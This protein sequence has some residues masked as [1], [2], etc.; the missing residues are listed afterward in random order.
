MGCVGGKMTKGA[1]ATWQ[2]RY[3]TM[4]PCECKDEK[5][6]NATMYAEAKKQLD[7]DP[8]VNNWVPRQIAKC[9]RGYFLFQFDRP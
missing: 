6:M 1:K 5:G 8:K 3:G 2:T 7:D 9:L 4:V